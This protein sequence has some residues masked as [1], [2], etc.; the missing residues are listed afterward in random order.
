M[1]HANGQTWAKLPG[2]WDALHALERFPS[3][4]R[5]GIPDVHRLEVDLDRDL[6]L[7]SYLTRDDTGLQHRERIAHTFLDDYRI[8]RL[9]NRPLASWTRIRRFRAA[10]APDFSLYRDWTLICNLW[11]IYRARWVAC[12]WQSR[13]VT[14]IPVANWTDQDSYEWCF[15][16]LPFRATL[17]IGVPDLRDH[18][19]RH[20]FECGYRAMEEHLE[21]RTV[22][23]YGTLPFRS[24]IAIEHRPDWLALRKHTAKT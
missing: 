13:G 23:V 17:A 8:E 18:L 15:A 1:P 22:I 10:L 24:D 16:G 20:L 14:V 4:N 5:F 9:W 12:F 19:T 3:S 7:M 6:R 21:P 11:N 2:G